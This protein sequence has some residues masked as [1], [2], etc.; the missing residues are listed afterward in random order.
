VLGYCTLDLAIVKV[1]K[2]IITAE[3]GRGKEELQNHHRANYDPVSHH[4]THVFLRQ[5]GQA[6]VKGVRQ[7]MRAASGH[8]HEN[9]NL[10]SW[11][12]LHLGMCHTNDRNL[13]V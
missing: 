1:K 11:T 12:P 3:R 10:K 2:S 6:I 7:C 8:L 9:C 13:F 4:L 5:A